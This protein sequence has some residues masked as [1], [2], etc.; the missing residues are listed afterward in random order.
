MNCFSFI[1]LGHLVTGSR[2]KA[3]NKEVLEVTP[4]LPTLDEYSDDYYNND[5]GGSY[6]QEEGDGSSEDMQ[7]D[8]SSDHLLMQQQQHHQQQSEYDDVEDG[9]Y[10][11][12]MSS[13][14]QPEVV[15]Q[16]QQQ[17]QKKFT[18]QLPIQTSSKRSMPTLKPCPRAPKLEPAVRKI[19]APVR[20]TQIQQQP[21]R[22]IMA[23]RPQPGSSSGIPQIRKPVPVSNPIH[24]RPNMNVVQHQPPPVAQRRTMLKMKVTN[25]GNGISSG[26]GGSQKLKIGVT[27]CR[28]IVERIE[29]YLEEVIRQTSQEMDVPVQVVR[30]IWQV[31]DRIKQGNNNHAQN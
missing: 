29:Q 3:E 8:E 2:V 22:L 16:Q 20:T 25:P 26:G 24:S 27:K 31:K 7:Y 14:L 12:E 30:G 13:Y 11:D 5:N 28:M 23:R 21:Q 19:P 1:F 9:G 4:E 18:P 15:M 17:Q 6:Y 10:E